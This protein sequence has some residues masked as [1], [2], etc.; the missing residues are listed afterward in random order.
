MRKKSGFRHVVS[1]VCTCRYMYAEPYKNLT[2]SHEYFI[3][4]QIRLEAG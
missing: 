1:N 4:L 2:E 3:L